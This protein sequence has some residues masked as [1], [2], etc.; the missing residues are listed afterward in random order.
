MTTAILSDQEL[1]R[2]IFDTIFKML[3]E[4]KKVYVRICHAR[5]LWKECFGNDDRFDEAIEVLRADGSI[6]LHGG[7]PGTLTHAMVADSYW[8]EYG[9]KITMRKRF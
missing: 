8:D 4:P 9:V 3:D 1:Y 2:E 7:D 5:D 6:S